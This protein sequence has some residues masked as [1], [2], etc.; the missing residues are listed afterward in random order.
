MDNQIKIPHQTIVRYLRRQLAA[1]EKAR[2]QTI[3]Q[4]DKSYEF[5]FDLLDTL[6]SKATLKKQITDTTPLSITF[7]QLDD[8]LVAIFAG[9]ATRQQAQQFIDA[10][11]FT[12]IFYERLLVRLPAVTPALA[13]VE[14]AEMAQVAIQSDEA[15]LRERISRKRDSSEQ[16]SRLVPV[17]TPLRRRLGE[18]LDW[19]V[20]HPGYAV[21]SALAV[22][23]IA[24]LLTPTVLQLL[25]DP[26]AAYVYDQ[27]IPYPYSAI[28]FR[29]PS[30]S[31]QEE[32]DHQTLETQFRAAMGDYLSRKYERALLRL[33]RLLPL[34]DNLLAQTPEREALAIF[35][36]YYFYLGVSHFALSRSRERDLTKEGVRQHNRAAIRY[37]AR[38]QTLASES[39]PDS[40]DRE[41]F[42]L[43]LAYGFGQQKE[44]AA[45]QL[46]II[47][48][49][50]S[51]YEKSVSLIREWSE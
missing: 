13:M 26:Y 35:R 28:I 29:S 2:I 51:H 36:D 47:P 16:R 46:R 42:F 27:R 50:S 18:W 41:T 23:F 31:P 3:K 11:M 4:E 43:G 5:L 25:K 22:V 1:D 45:E 9:Q 15:I 14:V 44:K 7:S 24:V 12:P 8:L 10:L 32:S 30:G 48:E 38:A 39:D 6:R 37:L 17:A 33:E 21:G 20:G 34:V 19:V 40:M 49:S